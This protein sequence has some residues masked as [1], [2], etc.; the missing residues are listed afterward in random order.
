MESTQSLYISL[1][2]EEKSDVL[3]EV[4]AIS[5]LLPSDNR[6]SNYLILYQAVACVRWRDLRSPGTVVSQIRQQHRLDQ[7]R[8]QRD[9]QA[10][11]VVVA[12]SCLSLLGGR[13]GKLVVTVELNYRTKL[14]LLIILE[15]DRC[16]STFEFSWILRINFVGKLSLSRCHKSITSYPN[17]CN[18]AFLLAW[19]YAESNLRMLYWENI[20]KGNCQLSSITIGD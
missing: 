20:T 1:F 19:K 7:G 3:K 12:E 14:H 5:S 6:V 15:H 16:D 8:V 9:L 10:N 13:K 17:K 2:S 11:I 4:N 18:R